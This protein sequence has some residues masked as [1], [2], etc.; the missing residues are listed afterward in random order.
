MPFAIW[1][2]KGTVGGF[3]DLFAILADV[4]FSHGCG[5]Q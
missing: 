1:P 2:N 3:G 5:L 4:F